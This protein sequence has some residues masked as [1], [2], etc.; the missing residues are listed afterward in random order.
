MKPI[1]L[2]TLALL[3]TLSANGIAFERPG[4]KELAVAAVERNERFWQQIASA[5]PY[6][7]MGIRKV[8]GYALVLCE[9]RQHPD[10]LARLFEIAAAAQD[11]D[12][13][14]PGY[15]NFRWTWRD[16]RVTD[17]NAVE[18]CMQDALRIWWRHRDWVP[19]PAREQLRELMDLSVEGCL[20]HRVPTSYTNIAILNAGNLIGLGESLER[21]DAA[22]DGY[23]RLAAVCLWTWRSGTHEY[24]SPTYYAVDIDGLQLIAAHAG[25]EEGRRQAKALLELFWTDIAL[26]WF[27]QAERLAGSQ[28]RSYDYLRGLGG[29][30]HVLWLNGWA[31]GPQPDPGW[32]IRAALDRW[33]PPE[34]LRQMSRDRFPRL[35]RQSWGPHPAESRIHMMY[36]DITLSSSAAAYGLQ[37]MPLTVDL[38]GTRDQLRCYF[39]ADGR[40]DPY[41]KK[42]YETSSARH[43]K[44]LHLRPFWTAA[45]R[46]HD[47]VGLVVYRPRDLTADVV[48]NLQSHFVF[49]AENQGLWLGGKPLDVPRATAD[50]PARIELAD[51]DSLVIR[52]GTAAVGVRVLWTRRQDGSPAPA[53]LVNDGN[54]YGVLRLTVDHAANDATVEA[55]AAFWLRV[56]SGLDTDAVFNKW[57]HEFQ[58]ATPTLVDAS[59][60]QVRVEVP[61][62]NGPVSVTA[63]AP[64]GAGDVELVPQPTRGVLELDAKEIGR[65]LLEQ[66]QSVA[67]Y[68]KAAESLQPLKVSAE[69]EVTWEAEDGLVFPGMS[70]AEDT[71]AS[72]GRYVWHSPRHRWGYHTGSVSWKL[73]VSH[74]GRYY[75]W[76]RIVAPDPETDSFW[77]QAFDE[78]NKL[79][80]RGEWH[81]ER[82]PDWFWCPTTLDRAKAPTPIELPAGPT[83]LEFR[84]REPGTKIDRL[85]ITADPNYRP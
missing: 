33:P 61:G 78:N 68:I 22:D 56:G 65:P 23:R 24:C 67:R 1:A 3:I 35:V 29:V 49:R 43:M 64:Y 9:A 10:R 71:K 82:G 80:F 8:F 85:L 46:S 75:L 37:D 77:V 84:P 12:P 32:L 4:T 6:E 2:P 16:E 21:S 53:T 40:E 50:S 28:S 69:G 42:K 27:P 60:E 54:P 58:K 55:G 25:R 66:T 13:G 57:L 76:G 14:S 79:V 39:I 74:P 18:F 15:G 20:R 52:Y 44:A 31:D 81:T 45:Q 83:R 7:T 63:D 19:E 47:A 17:R 41:G 72:G 70:V 26:N 30:N 38:P 62:T 11:R 51:G 5:E 34:R 48:T 36:P 59:K 73:R